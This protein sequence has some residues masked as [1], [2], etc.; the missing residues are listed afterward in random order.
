MPVRDGKTAL[1]PTGQPEL[2]D[3]SHDSALFAGAT[4]LFDTEL[5]LEVTGADIDDVLWTQTFYVGT[6]AWTRVKV[7][8]SN[9]IISLKAKG[10][11]AREALM[12]VIPWQDAS[13]WQY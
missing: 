10:S 9:A 5:D 7:K 1:C 13:D 11:E 6:V 4:Y 3:Y 8:D 12:Q 2:I